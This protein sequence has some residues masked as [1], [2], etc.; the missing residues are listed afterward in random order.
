MPIPRNLR[1]TLYYCATPTV[2]PSSTTSACS[3]TN[4]RI[5]SLPLELHR[6]T[7]VERLYEHRTDKRSWE[8]YRWVAEY[9]NAVVARQL[10]GENRLLVPADETTWQFEPFA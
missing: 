1:R 8:K 5:R 3:S 7:V 10:R 6:D 4:R 9:H 2:R